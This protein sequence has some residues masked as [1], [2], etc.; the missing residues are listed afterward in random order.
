MRGGKTTTH[1]R[2]QIKLE[3]ME[4]H[5]SKSGRQRT[6]RGCDTDG[7]WKVLI[8]NGTISTYGDLPL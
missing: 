2:Q 6:V 4:Y 1:E 5:K 3:S 7:E 8:E